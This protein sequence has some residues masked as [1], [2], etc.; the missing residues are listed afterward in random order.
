MIGIGAPGIEKEGIPLEI[1]AKFTIPDEQHFQRL[2]RTTS[3][4]GFQLGVVRVQDLHD[5][6]LDTGDRALL[7]GGYACRLRHHDQGYLAT[8]K[9][10]GRAS[11]PVHRRVEHQVVLDAPLPPQDWPPSPV[12]DLA[13]QFCHDRP[14]VIL[15][16]IKQ[17]RHNRS[18]HAG[19]RAV[20]RL[21]L[22]R[23]HVYHPDGGEPRATY[24]ELEA[25]LLPEGT[26]HDLEDL[27]AGLAAWGLTPQTR[28]KFERALATLDGPARQVAAAG[29]ACPSF[30]PVEMLKQPGLE[31]DEPMSEAGRKTFRFHFRR[32]LYHEPGTR[33]GED[34]E[35]LHDMR[36]ASRRMRAAFRVFGDFY[37]T[38]AVAPYRKGLKRTGRTLGAVRDLDVFRAK[39]Q[40]Y[41]AAARD[42]LSPTEQASLDE[43]LVILEGRREAARQ[44]LI[45]Y[46]DSDKYRRFVE[47]FGDFVETE[48]LACLPVDPGDGVPIPYR[49]RHVA[50]ATV[51]RRLAA[52]RA[53]DEWVTIPEP[54]LA[55]LHALRIACK[56]LRYTL[57]FFKEVLGPEAR[58]VIKEIVA[59]QDHLGALQDTV[60]AG[61]IL[62]EYLARGTWGPDLPAAA[63]PAGPIEAPGVEAYLA[64]TRAERRHLLD[65]FPQV[66]QKLQAAE[67]GHLMAQVVAVL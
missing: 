11:G 52:V 43:F 34:I 46:L 55:R 59:V 23:V 40:D 45:T 35:A 8:L 16:E 26:E 49:V 44:R 53:Y 21:S 36:V 31:P 9:G 58:A 25:E 18:L 7:A 22:D 2:L 39:I 57:E 10:L 65:T 60:V 48:G 29:A 27:V 13:L 54:P 66:W 24:L 50:P 12:Q 33:L 41:Q 47:R 17:Q 64:S 4:A 28:S 15:F 19:P 6:Y 61:G 20:A 32:M 51:Y 63:R 38:G 5:R 1:E 30:P 62:E 67:F 56:R 37:A 14:L 42:S 3:L